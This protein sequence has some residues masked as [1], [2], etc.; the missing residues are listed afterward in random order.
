MN[1][2]L[3]LG[4]K[5]R[6]R[7]S[8]AGRVS[9]IITDPK[10]HQ[11]TYLVVK[12][13]HLFPKQVVVPVSL[14]SDVTLEEVE[15][16]TTQEALAA[17]PDYEVTLPTGTYEKP[18]PAPRNRPAAIYTPPANKGFMVLR[19]RSI[20]EESVP[21]EKGMIVRDCEGYQVGKVEGLVL[22]A[23]Q[24]QGK[25]IAMR[26]EPPFSDLQVIPVELVADA[27]EGEIHLHITAKQ[28]EGL[29]AYQPMPV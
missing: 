28:A 8:T 9:K 2:L 21:V 5:V 20:P 7:D 16:D 14:V 26:R 19:Q 12:R 27:Q 13:G 1:K 4:T 29:A 10:S 15:L 24:H 18:F 3:K 25:Y 22:D 6:T 17:F 11:P 23:E